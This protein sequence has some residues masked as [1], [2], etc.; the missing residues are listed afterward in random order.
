MPPEPVWV[1]VIVVVQRTSP[2]CP[3]RVGGTGPLLPKSLSH[4]LPGGLTAADIVLAL[5]HYGTA[6]YFSSG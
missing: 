5:E 3:T 2:A 4:R 1:R 6:K